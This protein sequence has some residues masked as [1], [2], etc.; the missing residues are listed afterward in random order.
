M[1]R[2]QI[3]SHHFMKSNKFFKRYIIINENLRNIR[4]IELYIEKQSNLSLYDLLQHYLFGATAFTSVGQQLSYNCRRAVSPQKSKPAN[5]Q[6]A[7]QSPSSVVTQDLYQ[8]FFCVRIICSDIQKYCFQFQLIEK[9]IDS[10]E[11][12]F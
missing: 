9:Y 12:T 7:L 6:K 5:L 4:T 2:F 11:E 10:Y 3:I 1:L 8:I